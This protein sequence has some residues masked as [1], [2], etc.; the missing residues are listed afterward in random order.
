MPLMPVSA[1]KRSW[2]TCGTVPLEL[3]A[4]KFGVAM[5]FRPGSSTCPSRASLSCKLV[6]SREKT[7]DA[8]GMMLA[9][10]VLQTTAEGLHLHE[11]LT[12]PV[13]AVAGADEIAPSLPSSPH[14]NPA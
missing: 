6:S 5:A 10:K 11:S 2:V 1:A 14:P 12:Q 3:T 7:V 4:I 9:R 8:D 13:V